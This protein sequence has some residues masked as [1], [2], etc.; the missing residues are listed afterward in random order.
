[1]A[2]DDGSRDVK[3]CRLILGLKNQKYKSPNPNVFVPVKVRIASWQLTA[4]L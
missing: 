3:I 1:M 2:A 4:L